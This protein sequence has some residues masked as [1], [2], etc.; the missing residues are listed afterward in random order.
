MTPDEKDALLN[1]IRKAAA[2]NSNTRLTRQ[3]FLKASG[4]KLADLFRHFPKWFD[5]LVA[6]GIS[7]DPYNQRIPPDDLLDDWGQITCSKGR[8]PTR[9]ESKLEGSFS[10]T[11]FDR[12]FWSWSKIPESFRAFALSKP[13]WADAV[14]LLPSNREPSS[15]TPSQTVPTSG[16]RTSVIPRSPRLADRPTYGDPINFRGWRHEPVNEDGIVFL[17]GM[18]ARELGFLVE[19]VQAGFP[20][21]EAKCQIAP[22]KWQRVRIEFEFESRNFREHG[23]PTDGCDIIVCWRHNWS[24]CPA[25]LEVVELASL[26][27]TLP[28][29]D[30]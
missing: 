15:P 5:A 7:V 24:E 4:L 3:N 17:F 2:S 22:G 30:E 12:N 11:V 20:D 6:A 14:E 18:V 29:T 13:E 10:P 8:I 19:A 25:D 16:T 28:D 26:I 21:C 9:N 23:H 1:A 27:S